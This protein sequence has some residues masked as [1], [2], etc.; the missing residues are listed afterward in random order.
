M[1]TRREFMQASA[2]FFV[3]AFLPG[4]IA[5]NDR[6]RVG[7]AGVKGRGFGLMRS[8]LE[9]GQDGNVEV[10]ALCDVDSEVLSQ[11]AANCEKLNGGKP[12]AAVATCG[13]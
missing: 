7:I 10:A 5:A 2:L 4:G 12:V 8:L 3:P 1:N 6:I 11:R 13:G 9:M